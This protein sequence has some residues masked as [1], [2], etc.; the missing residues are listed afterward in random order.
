V[1]RDPDAWLSRSI[2]VYVDAVE[3]NVAKLAEA[4]RAAL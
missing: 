4:I 2:L 1:R 3:S